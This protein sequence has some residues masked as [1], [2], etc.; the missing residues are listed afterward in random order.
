MDIPLD[1]IGY[2]TYCGEAGLGNVDK[3]KI[4]I[5]GGKDPKDYVKQYQLADSIERQL[6]WKTN[7]MS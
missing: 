5:L 3:S 7:L 4:E 1:N 6:E 2:L